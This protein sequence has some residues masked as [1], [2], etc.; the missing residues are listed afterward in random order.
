VYAAQT[1]ARLAAA[2]PHRALALSRA[3]STRAKTL[4][5]SGLVPARRLEAEASLLASQALLNIGRLKEA[6]AVAGDARAAFASCGNEPF[7]EALCGYFEGTAAAF[8]GEFAFAERELK[9]ATRVFAA[10]EQDTWT[11]RAEAALG[12]LYSQR[13]N[14]ARAIPFLQSALDRMGEEK[15]AHARTA[16][17]INLAA[18]LA[19][20]GAYEKSR[21]V[22]AQALADARRHDLGYLVFGIR[23]GLAELDLLRGETGRALT[24]FDTLAAEADET[25]LEEDRVFARLH[26]AECLGR[27][28]R[29]DE[30]V[31][32]L[33]ELRSFV[34][35]TT[36][37]GVPAWDE[38]AA[39][40][41]RGVQDGLLGQVQ[42]CLGALSGGFN[43]SAR[44]E[45]RRA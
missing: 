6:R 7:D 42:A 18:A 41:D 37:A 38:L 31:A 35:I 16:T 30:M 25:Q 29:I 9:R 22:Y 23:L 36:L 14:P 1:G 27:L 17:E 5:S 10:F 24:A 40:L 28:S 45:R 2:E 43:V 44:P 39:R 11:A 34:T 20:T 21:S 19:H 33:E 26:A 3:L 13:G 8:E 4:P 12:T 32:R 15:D